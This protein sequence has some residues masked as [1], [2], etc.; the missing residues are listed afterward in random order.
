[1][2]V[3]MYTVSTDPLCR[4]TKQYF[5]EKHIPFEYVDYDLASEPEQ[6]KIGNELIKYTGSISFPFVDID[7]NVVIGYNPEKYDELIKQKQVA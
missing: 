1:M 2:K 7:G 3:R 4:K 5:R 6:E